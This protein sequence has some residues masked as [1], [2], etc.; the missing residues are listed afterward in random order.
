MHWT[1]T[2]GHTKESS[3]FTDDVVL[4]FLKHVAE[5]NQRNVKRI[6]HDAVPGNLD[7]DTFE[8]LSRYCDTM[9]YINREGGV[10]N[11][12]LVIAS[13]TKQG[14]EYIKENTN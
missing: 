6:L 3:M 5:R 9:G 2:S 8:A 7:P 11:N 12:T 14:Y 4:P 13:M 1:V 10:M